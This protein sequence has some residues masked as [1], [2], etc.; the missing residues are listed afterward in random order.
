MDYEILIRKG[1]D[2]ITCRLTAQDIVGAKTRAAELHG[3]SYDDTQL[4]AIIDLAPQKP[5]VV[6]GGGNR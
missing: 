1:D 5:L 6:C 2:R 3:V 4:L